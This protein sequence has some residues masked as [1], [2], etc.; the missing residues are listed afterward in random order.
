MFERFTDKARA[1]VVS[2]NTMAQER[3]DDEIRPAHMLYGLAVSDGVAARPLSGCRRLSRP[4]SAL[5]RASDLNRFLPN[6]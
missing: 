3:G 5:L 4:R 6:R 2:A 1:V